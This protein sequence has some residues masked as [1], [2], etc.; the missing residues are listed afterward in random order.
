MAQLIRSYRQVVA[1]PEFLHWSRHLQLRR[2]LTTDEHPPPS[3][4]ETETNS[5]PGPKHSAKSP[6]S[7][8]PLFSNPK[9]KAVIDRM[10][11][12]DH[13]GE[14]G[15]R[16][17][18]KGQL[19]ILE[20]SSV[21]P[22]IQEMA[23]Q[24][25]K[26]LREFER[27]MMHRRVRPTALLPFWNVAGFALGMGTALL[28]KKAA[29]ACTVAVEEVI[30]EHYN[31]QIRTLLSS[32]EFEDEDELRETF[33]TFRDEELEHQHIGEKHDAKQ[34]PMYEALTQVIKAGC[35]VAIYTSER[36]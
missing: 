19:A 7:R 2:L 27:L 1:A 29:M 8:S 15:A 16:Q 21:G 34:A 20:N 13:A 30:G 22:I 26:H 24:E 11:R 28:G 23:T 10:I 18:Y 17:I 4:D 35:R 3:K 14:L 32:K 12:V 6:R 5:K 25:V 36:I 33:K 9:Y 31:D